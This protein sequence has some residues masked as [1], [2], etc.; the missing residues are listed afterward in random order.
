ML[1]ERFGCRREVILRMIVEDL[2]VDLDVPLEDLRNGHIFEDGSPWT[3]RL[4]RGTVDT[5]DAIDRTH[6]HP[7]Q[8][9]TPCQ[10]SCSFFLVNH[11]NYPIFFR[12]A[13]SLR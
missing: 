6:F 12:R 7:Y 1:P 4:A 8:Q 10:D 2:R 3:F 9:V 11:Y 5:L 13:F